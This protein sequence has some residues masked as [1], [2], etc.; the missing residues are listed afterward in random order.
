MK[1][2]YDIEVANLEGPAARVISGCQDEKT[3]TVCWIHVEQIT[4]KKASKAFRNLKETEYCYNRFD[5]IISVSKTVQDDFCSLIKV[6]VPCKVLYNT[7]ETAQILQKSAKAVPENVIKNNCFNW[8]GVGKLLPNKGF[9]RMLRLQKRLID[10]GYMVHFYALGVGEQQSELEQYCKDNGIAE[11]VTFLGYQLNP[12]KYV[13]KCDLYVCASH[14]EGF[15]TAATEALIVGTP[16]VTTRVSGME[17][18]LGNNEF[19]IITDN[20][21]NALYEGIKKLQELFQK[22]LELFL[23]I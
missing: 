1:E 12:Y 13:A 23:K 20:D 8:C 5:K 19:G 11:N 15:S 6:T 18:M 3:K 16:V 7:N 17:E 9:D 14:A 10:D 21:E 2:H 22:L 4:T